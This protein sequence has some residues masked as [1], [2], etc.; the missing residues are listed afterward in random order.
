MAAVAP[1]AKETT[2]TTGIGTISLQGAVAGHQGIVAA[3]GTGNT[4]YFSET[5]GLN[6]QTFIGTV[7]AGSP[8]TIAIGSILNSSASGS[9]ISWIAGS[10]DVFIIIPAE[11]VIYADPSNATLVNVP[12][13]GVTV[14]MGGTGTATLTNHGLL[15]GSS[16]SPVRALAVAA[17]GTVLT[18]VATADPT[19]TATPVLGVN[20]SV[21]GTLGLAN[22]G[23]SGATTTVTPSAVTA[24]TT[25]TL[26]ATTGTLALL[27]ANTFTGTQ[28]FPDGST[29]TSSGITAGKAVTLSPASFNVV[30]SPTGTGVVTINPA[31]TGSIANVTGSFTTLAA[32]STVSGT[33][34][35]TYLAS[36]P[37][38]GGSA[39]AAGSFTT[40]SASSTVSGSGFSTYL[41]SPPAIGGTAAA[42]GTFTTLS[43]TTS[44]IFGGVS[45]KESLDIAS[46][47]G[48]STNKI[49]IAGNAT[50][51]GPQIYVG[52]VDT[53]A[54]LLL[55]SRGNSPIF[56][57]TGGGSGGS[58]GTTQAQLNG[59]GTFQVSSGLANSITFAGSATNPTIA[60]TA[61]NLAVTPNTTIAGGLDGTV[62]GANTPMTVTGINIFAF[63]ASPLLGLGSTSATADHGKWLFNSGAAGNLFF[64]AYKDDYSANTTA[65]QITRGTTY[66]VASHTWNT[67]TVA[68]TAVQGM[69]L[70]TTALTVGNGTNTSFAVTSPGASAFVN[71]YNATGGTT[72]SSPIL[73]IASTTDTNVGARITTLGTGPL[74]FLSGGNT[75][76]Q[77][78]IL[79]NA[80]GACYPTVTSGSAAG[81]LS[82]NSGNLTANS[83]GGTT[84]LSDA[85]LAFCGTGSFGGADKAVFVANGNTPPSTN[86]TG[87]GIIYI[88][89]GSLKYRG[90]SGTVTTLA[91]A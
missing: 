24:A 15:L 65:Y 14:T 85:L 71:Y 62:I 23:G 81:A 26:P 70:T 51:F 34:F 64:Q 68:G 36:P 78:Q 52:G 53:N 50:G 32:S 74:S 9:A 55:T 57:Q 66:N 37:A 7:T 31:T 42:A 4:A 43:A 17:S 46:G 56:F 33:G 61:G 25:I 21:T 77:F 35:S 19:F 49:V 44:A 5:D 29:I 6:W 45:G 88:A 72:G 12:N 47:G 10:K 58:G 86:P 40:L 16:T 91:A 82:T 67:S 73:S 22:G 8:D 3:I 28:T 76:F 83:A 1:F 89:A 79:D 87:G 54:Y 11:R 18:G 60:T 48:V 80:S 90:S 13:A 39:P 69:Q 63:N 27:G 41:A 75:R 84:T 38:I 20:A 2:I 30:I 59:S